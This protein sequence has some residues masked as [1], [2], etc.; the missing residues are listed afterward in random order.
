MFGEAFFGQNYF[1]ETAGKSL[2]TYPIAKSAQY[3]IVT[4]QKIID[5]LV[6]SLKTGHTSTKSLRYDID[7]SHPVTKAETY[8]ILISH[9]LTKADVYRVLTSHAATKS[10]SAA[11]TCNRTTWVSNINAQSSDYRLVTYQ[12]PDGGNWHLAT[13]NSMQIGYILS[14]TGTNPI[15]VSTVWAQI[16]TT[17]AITNSKFLPLF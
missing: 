12:D 8:R 9:T 13:L 16:E 14:A 5:S 2:A 11:F 10:Q 17:P 1:G 3:D 7:T 6:Y 4:R 15:A